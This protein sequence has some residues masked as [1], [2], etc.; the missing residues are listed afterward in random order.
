MQDFLYKVNFIMTKEDRKKILVILVFSIFISIIEIIG[1]SAIMPFIAIVNNTEYI[2]QNSI[3]QFVY[4][5]FQFESATKY[6]IFFGLLLICFY[7]F[8]ALISM[9]YFYIVSRFA[10]GKYNKISKIIFEKILHMN[11][12]SFTKSKSAD[13]SKSIINEAYNFT[14]VII[15][16]LN[17]FTEV[18]VVICI[19][20]LMLYVDF[21]LTLFISFILLI[22]VSLLIKIVSKK[23]KDAGNKREIS[24]K[25]FFNIV[26]STFGNYKMVKLSSI[27]QRATQ[28]QFNNA[29]EQFTDANIISETMSQL[30]RVF[31]EAVTFSLLIGIVFFLMFSGEQNFSN[32]IPVLSLLLLGLYRLMPSAN[33]ILTAYGQ[34]IY[35]H[36]SIDVVFNM[37]QNSQENLGDDI[38]KF[39]NKIELKNLNFSYDKNS[40]ILNN[41]D[42]VI[43]KGEKVAFI[44]PSGSG[45]STLVDIIIGLIP[46]EDF[47]IYVDD[48]KINQSNILSLRNKVGYIPQNVYLFDGTIADNVCLGRNRDDKKLIEVLKKAQIYDFLIEYKNGLETN[49]G[50]GGV[51]FSGGQKQRIAIARALYSEP[52]ILIL[53]EA[54]SALDEKTEQDIMSEIIVASEDKTLIIIAHRLNTI[55]SCDCVYELNNG[56]LRIVR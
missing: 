51:K 55:K 30:P 31:L 45:K 29:S 26:S 44:G 22:S 43:N 33:R 23:I 7:I 12:I 16:F 39:K 50:D 5:F 6:I 46:V 47:Q 52:E 48:S 42:L 8:R 21:K 38:V 32:K 41:I 36:K 34:I 28:E 17:I 35:A 11:Y 40:L 3:L 24:Q 18:F 54:T 1:I 15:A 13:F 27:N 20:V 53:D 19:Y 49:V 9:F 37:Y 2:Q 56:T 4:N 14:T 25:L 10:R